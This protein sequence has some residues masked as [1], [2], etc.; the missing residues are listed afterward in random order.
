MARFRFSKTRKMDHFW[1][2]WSTFVYPATL[3]MLNET[4][5]VIF[6]HRAWAKQSRIL[7]ANYSQLCWKFVA[8]SWLWFFCIPTFFRLCYCHQPPQNHEFLRLIF[9]SINQLENFPL[10]AHDNQI[11]QKLIG[12]VEIPLSLLRIAKKVGR[13]SG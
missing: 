10:S 6:K 1:H 12:K 9:V 5:S 11:G 3:A 2:F 7:Q 4:F 13:A 8:H